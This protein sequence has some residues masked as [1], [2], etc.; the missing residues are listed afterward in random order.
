MLNPY[1][2]LWS[3]IESA[4]IRRL[5]RRGWSVRPPVGSAHERHVRR[6]RRVAPEFETCG[7]AVGGEVGPSVFASSAA[8][9][10]VI[11][12]AFSPPPEPR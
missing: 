4:A 11:G 12:S 2:W 7:Q 5:E 3:V 10:R 1:S 9:R 6:S 8:P